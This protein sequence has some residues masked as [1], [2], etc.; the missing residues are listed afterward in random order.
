MTSLE[1]VKTLLESEIK[2][3]VGCTEP[4][5]VAFAFARA[6][7]LFKDNSS[8]RALSR[9]FKADVTVSRDV[10][11]N[12][13]TVKVPVIKLKGLEAAAACGIFTKAGDFNPFAGIGA[14][15]KKKIK[16]LLKRKNWLKVSV[17][18]TDG[19]SVDAKISS[20]KKTARVTVKDSHDNITGLYFSGKKL[21]QEKKL[22]IRR[23]RDLN[24]IAFIV[25][26]RPKDAEAFVEKFIKEQGKLYDRY[27][28][29]DVFEAVAGLV[30]KRMEGASIKVITLTGSGNQGLFIGIPFYALYKKRGRKILPAALFAVLSQIYLTYGEGRISDE[31]GLAGKASAALCG[32]LSFL[33]GCGLKKIKAN[34]DLTRKALKGLKC[35]GAEPVCALKARLALTAVDDVVWP[36]GGGLL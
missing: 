23:I 8:P 4:A 14:A 2:E 3:V 10:A 22:S 6:V 9:D 27:G 30:K 36:K 24:E 12:I 20:S 34:M 25:S 15:E 11:R 29:T 31:C 28:H 19:V 16:V 18:N 7:K 32:G 26:K 33:N 1:S 5:S 17:K 21:P 35:E 13:S